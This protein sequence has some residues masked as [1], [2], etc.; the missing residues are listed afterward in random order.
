MHACKRCT[1]VKRCTPMRYTPICA[2]KYMPVRCTPMRCTPMRC[3]P[4]RCTPVRCTP[5]RYMPLRYM[6]VRCHRPYH[7][8]HWSVIGDSCAISRRHGLTMR[9]FFD[10][11]PRLPSLR[12]GQAPQSSA[13]IG[14]S[15]VGIRKVVDAAIIV[16]A[17]LKGGRES[18][19]LLAGYLAEGEGE[20]EREG[21]EV[22][23]RP[24]LR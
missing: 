21:E 9:H 24:W 19:R 18:R 3:T 11:P 22:N 2:Y 10:S 5:L 6:P 20:C 16:D 1:P 15:T 4:V 12:N 7:G 13:N 8:P 17:W 14:R 23:A